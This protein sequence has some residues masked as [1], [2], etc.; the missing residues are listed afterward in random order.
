MVLSKRPVC[1]DD[2]P[3]LFELYCSV[4][5]GE[6]FFGGLDSPQLSALLK[7]QFEAR[8]RAYQYRYPDGDHQIILIDE[9]PIGRIFV[10]RNEQEIRLTDIALLTEYRGK[11]I[12]AR[13]ITELFQESDLGGKPVTLHVEM[14]NPA[15]RLYNRLGFEKKGDDGAYI[16]MERLASPSKSSGA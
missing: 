16:M 15:I 10:H 5:D 11:G 6:G 2:Q 4:R 12:G 3:F 1:A 13:L 8:E 14:Q 7:M 9:K